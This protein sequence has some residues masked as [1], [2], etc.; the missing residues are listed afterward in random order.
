MPM[1]VGDVEDILFPVF[2]LA[3]I[4]MPYDSH[5]VDTA[6][7]GADGAIGLM[8]GLGAYRSQV[9]CV[10]RMPLRA[11]KIPAGS[12]RKLAT[13][14]EALRSLCFHDNENLLAKTR[15]TAVGYAHN[16]VVSRFAYILERT[17][18][19][20]RTSEISLTQETIAEMMYA[21]RTSVTEAA[22][23]LK[24]AGIIDYSRGTITILDR[25]V[26]AR[27]CSVTERQRW[28]WA[29]REFASISR[30]R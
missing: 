27:S 16:P 29:S 7:V 24:K 23:D 22:R 13:E 9:S 15:I 5:Q 28:A 12:Y 10:V 25:S 4:A 17:A 19:I 26:V 1:A 18:D 8:A 20:L 30:G 2:G 6:I 3:S 21:R 11:L 14:D